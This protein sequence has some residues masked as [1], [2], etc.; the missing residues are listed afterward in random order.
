M[1][2][3]FI[4][5][6]RED[7]EFV[8][9][10]VD[11]LGRESLDTMFDMLIEPGESWAQSLIKSIESAEFFLVVMSPNYF[12]STWAQEEL[13]IGMLREMEKKA[14][15]IPLMVS[16]CKLE[17]FLA[18]KQYAD[19]TV[20]YQSGLK[21]LILAIN[22]PADEAKGQRCATAGQTIGV[23]TPSEIQ[24]LL[25]DLKEA[26]GVFK[27]QPTVE[28]AIRMEAG[29]TPVTSALQCFIIMPFGVESLDIVYEDFV[30][31]VLENDCHLICERGDDVFG[32]NIIMDDIENSIRASD[33]IVADLTGKNPNVFYEVGIS[34]TL[35][36]PVL[37]LAQAIDDVPFDLRHRRVLLYEYTPHGCKKL[38]KNLSEN[39]REIVKKITP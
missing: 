7:R 9:R 34:H 17:G 10:L 24:T 31:P 23:V 13:Q 28:T 4:S 27:N 20:D 3:C 22:E 29:S 2:R 12:S 35:K 18:K 15:V 30:K 38:E 26:V 8:N 11:D 33:L 39:I 16:P 37:L 32:S 36:K 5:Y 25:R 21:E 1:K 19:F 14:L 6:A